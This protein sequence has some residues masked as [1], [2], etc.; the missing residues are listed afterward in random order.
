MWAVCVKGSTSFCAAVRVVCGSKLTTVIKTLR[1]EAKGIV[2]ILSFK[3]FKWILIA[4]KGFWNKVYWRNAWGHRKVW[5]VSL[6]AFLMNFT[7]KVCAT[8]LHQT[9][10]HLNLNPRQITLACQSHFLQKRISPQ[11]IPSFLKN[12]I[13]SCR[14]PKS[15][16]HKIIL[17]CSSLSKLFVFSLWLPLP[18]RHHSISQTKKDWNVACM[19]QSRQW[20]WNWPPVASFIAHKAL[21]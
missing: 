10:V 18:S 17:F 7:L 8:N 4:P 9:F 21:V 19:K 2:Q 20:L 11:S 1:T 6:A 3:K 14:L 12:C 13:I 5:L 16:H 15:F